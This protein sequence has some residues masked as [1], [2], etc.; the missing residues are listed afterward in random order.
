MNFFTRDGADASG[1]A[2]PEPDMS[3]TWLSVPEATAYCEAQ[4]LSRNIKTIRRWA[5]RSH[6]RP[7]NAEVFVR[8]QDTENGFRY[9]I[10]K[11]SLDRKIAQELTFEAMRAKEDSHADT[12][13]ASPHMPAHV[14]A[15][16]DTSGHAF[17][18]D[19]P[20]T[21][22]Q[23]EPTGE[24]TPAGARKGEDPNVRKLEVTNRDEG[25]L[26]EQLTQ[27]DVQI[28]E[29]NEQMRRKDEHI[30][31]ML[32]RDK[33]T[34]ILIHRLQE[35]MSKSLDAPR[36]EDHSPRLGEGDSA[37]SADQRDRV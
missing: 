5:Q 9:A 18:E 20:Q 28:A 1:P 37:K 29:L 31:A 7:E 30:S 27:K 24:E 35:A 13:P 4:G 36:G 6:A 32:E 25:F 21:S 11:T 19:E 12:P 10:E 33:E 2:R 34:N 23:A 15:E 3:G 14:P 22:A 17:P 8:E 26:R 16:P